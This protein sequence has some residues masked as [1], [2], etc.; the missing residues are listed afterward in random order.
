MFANAMPGKE[1][2]R[3]TSICLLALVGAFVYSAS[4]IAQHMNAKDS[5]C[6]TAGSG[7]DETRC[8]LSAAEKADVKIGQMLTRIRHVINPSEQKDL[9]IAQDK[10]AQFREA[11]CSAER[12]LYDGGSA[13]P[14][15]Y[16]ACLEAAARQRLTD[17]ETI[18]S[19]RLTKFGPP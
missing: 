17:L 2:G 14:M 4:T 15:V 6:Q 16:Y 10:W 18:Y 19:G 9:K 7:A 12:G 8:F 11:N 3:H 1:M 13:A 5:P